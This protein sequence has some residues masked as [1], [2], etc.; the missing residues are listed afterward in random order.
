MHWTKNQ[1]NIYHTVSKSGVFHTHI[2]TRGNLP[3]I[4]LFNGIAFP[5]LVYL[6]TRRIEDSVSTHVLLVKYKASSGNAT[7][8]LDK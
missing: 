4:C 2:T 5:K 6:A 7:T 8:S 1:V 3:N